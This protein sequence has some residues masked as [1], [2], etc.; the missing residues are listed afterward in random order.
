[1]LSSALLTLVSAF[2]LLNPRVLRSAAA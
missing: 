2:L 1:V